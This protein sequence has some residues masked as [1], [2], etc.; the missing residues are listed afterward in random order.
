VKGEWGGKTKVRSGGKS[1]QEKT[2]ETKRITNEQEWWWC[3]VRGV[4]SP[5]ILRRGKREGT[6]L[7]KRE[8]Q[9]VRGNNY[10]SLPQY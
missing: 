3:F 7:E 8:M 10:M 4:R 2:P 6:I 5:T 1:H 9:P